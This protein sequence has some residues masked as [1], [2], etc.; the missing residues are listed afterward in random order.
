MSKD[1]EQFYRL[2]R[3]LE[4]NVD[5]IFSFALEKER[6]TGVV[7][8]K[9]DMIMQEYVEKMQQNGRV[10][11]TDIVKSSA[12]DFLQSLDKTSLFEFGGY[13]AQSSA[14]LCRTK[15]KKTKAAMCVQW[16]Q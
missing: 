2:I 13:V 10:I 7:G 14:L 1:K 16:F 15:Y 11:S 4:K 5:E 8:R 3:W 6:Q 9:M 12:M